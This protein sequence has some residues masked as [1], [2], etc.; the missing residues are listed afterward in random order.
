MTEITPQSLPDVLLIEP[1][2]FGDLRGYFMETYSQPR[3]A[4]AGFAGVFVQDNQSL[5]ATKGTVRGLHF[6]A[7]PHAQ[8]KLIRVTRGTIL[9]VAVDIRPGSP[10]YGQH[11]AVELSGDNARQLLV[12]AGFAH[13]FQTLTENCEVLYKVTDVYAPQAEGGLLWNDPA[14]EIDWPIAAD[15]ALV[16]A[17]DA[18]WPTLAELKSP[19]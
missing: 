4:Q 16:N 9:D 12:P 13:G 6:Q 19:F 18:A 5:S 8:A 7:P 3:L 14:L 1:K 11:V 10:T 17:R 2:R 15:Q